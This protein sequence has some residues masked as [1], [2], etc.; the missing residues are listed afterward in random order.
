MEISSTIAERTLAGVNELALPVAGASCLFLMV[1]AWAE[2]A[3]TALAAPRRRRVRVLRRGVSALGLLMAVPSPAAAGRRHPPAST[4]PAHEVRTEPG[5]YPPPR[6]LG[7]AGPSPAPAGIESP[8]RVPEPPDGVIEPPW[9]RPG[10]GAH[11]A[12]HGGALGAAPE[13]LFSRWKAAPPVGAEAG[14]EPQGRPGDG[15]RDPAAASDG[16]HQPA[17]ARREWHAVLPG[18]TLWSIAAER[19]RTDD[20]RRIARYWPRIHRANREVIGANP[21]LLRPGQVLELPPEHA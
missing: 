15:E 19:L 20:V 7:S 3:S 9:S 12:V 11:A 18:D 1:R 13:R 10:R 4:A 8:S 17:P 16:G 2:A 5:R 6:L 21:D 14:R